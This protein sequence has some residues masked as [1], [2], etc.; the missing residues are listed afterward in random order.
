M[1]GNPTEEEKAKARTELKKLTE[2]WREA[3]EKVEK[4]M[5]AFTDAGKALETLTD[6]MG[7]I[8]QI[9]EINPNEVRAP[10]EFRGAYR[11]LAR[12]KGGIR[13]SEG[14]RIKKV[15]KL[16][17]DLEKNECGEL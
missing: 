3:A 14:A 11:W 4:E 5:A 16:L 9:A 13:R 15:L 6:N 1:S 17:E 10:W 12:G 8:A 7:D 2:V